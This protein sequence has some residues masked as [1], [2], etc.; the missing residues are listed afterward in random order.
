MEPSFTYNG[1][2]LNDILFSLYSIYFPLSW[3]WGIVLLTAFP[4]FFT[5]SPIFFWY[6]G[7]K[8]LSIIWSIV[9]ALVLSLLVHALIND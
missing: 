3:T 8:R 7:W 5:L 1:E 4:W 9:W 2:P 6:R